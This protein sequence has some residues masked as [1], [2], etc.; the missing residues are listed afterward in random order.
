M[1]ITAAKPHS[2]EAFLELP[3]TKPASEFI[4]DKISQKPMPQAV[5]SGVDLTLTVTQIFE[6][7]SF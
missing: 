3:E 2:L 7:L 4:N 1:V 5:L 6:W